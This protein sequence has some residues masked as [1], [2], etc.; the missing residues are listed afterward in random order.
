[1]ER[2]LCSDHS[3]QDKESSVWLLVAVSG[4]EAGDVAVLS[5][6]TSKEDVRAVVDRIDKIKYPHVSLGFIEVPYGG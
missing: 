2:A 4:P 5:W 6:H 1:M 3:M